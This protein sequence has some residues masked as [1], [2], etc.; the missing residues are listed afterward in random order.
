MNTLYFYYFFLGFLHGLIIPQLLPLMPFDFKALMDWLTFCIPSTWYWNWH[1]VIPHTHAKFG[2]ISNDEFPLTCSF[3][4]LNQHI[5][6]TD[7]TAMKTS[8]SR[9]VVCFLETLS[10]SLN[11]LNTLQWSLIIHLVIPANRASC[12]VNAR[13]TN[14]EM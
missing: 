6:V 5:I 13:Q 3:K 9:V 14:K 2:S 4:Y 12:N 7:I 11:R 1:P 8:K 10:Q